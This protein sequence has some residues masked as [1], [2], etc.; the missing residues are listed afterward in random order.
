MHPITSGMQAVV[1]LMVALELKLLADCLMHPGMLATQLPS[2]SLAE[3]AK[4]MAEASVQPRTGYTHPFW[5]TFAN[6]LKL[7]AAALW[8]SFSR[9]SPDELQEAKKQRLK[10]TTETFEEKALACR[11]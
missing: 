8:S 2:S 9:M 10:A 5:C 11:I 7:M 4:L 3:L 6:E 1:L